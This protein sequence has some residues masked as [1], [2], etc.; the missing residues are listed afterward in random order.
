MNISARGGSQRP[1]I[2]VV[3]PSYNQGAYL[4]DT[5]ES[6]LGQGIVGLEYSVLDGGSTD[7][8]PAVLRRYSDRLDFVRSKPDRGQAAAINEGFSRSRGEILGWINSDDF[9]LP[10]ALAHAMARLNPNEPAI[11]CGNCLHFTQGGGGGRGSDVVAAARTQDL[12]LRDYIIQPASFFTRSAWELV[13]PLDESLT[14]VFD[15]E[16]FVRASN[17]GVRFITDERYLAAYRIHSEHKSGSGGQKR[18]L[19]IERLYTKYLGASY[20]RATRILSSRSRRVSVI[21][22]VIHKLGLEKSEGALFKMLM[23]SVLHGVKSQD[24]SQMLFN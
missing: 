22:R 24:V 20:G 2:S 3:T 19:E 7:E 10:G 18:A 15:W 8:S 4:A 1:T 16:W 23:P 17:A 5:I 13:G 11:L 21:H 9:Y 12:R 6:V 14:Y